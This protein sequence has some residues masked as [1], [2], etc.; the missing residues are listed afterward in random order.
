MENIPIQPE[1]NSTSNN[2]SAQISP[3]PNF[4]APDPNIP[5]TNQPSKV[6]HNRNVL[7]IIIMIAGLLL[8]AVFIILFLES[9][10]KSAVIQATAQNSCINHTYA[11]GSSGEC[12]SDIQTMVNFLETD[13][14]NECTFTGAKT[15]NING[16]FDATTES[17]VK[18]VQSWLSCYNKQEGA[19][20]N[21]TVSGTVDSGTWSDICTYAYL[22]PK[23]AGQSSSPFYK[24]A[25]IAGKNAGC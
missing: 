9:H 21:T 5:T 8:F 7:I 23:Q 15:L 14:L 17:Q 19:P 1:P 10:T 3:L 22:Y 6:P 20:N 4:V 25:I 13:N 2:T 11:N 18:V 24:Q 12:V 16:N